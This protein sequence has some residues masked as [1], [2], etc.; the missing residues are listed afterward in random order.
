MLVNRARNLRKNPTEAERKLWAH[1]RLRQIGGYKFRRQHPLGPFIVDFVCIEKRL[2]VEVDG[3]QHDEKRF[4]DAKRN[5][6][7]EEREFKVIRFWNN[8][9]LRD[10]EIV[11]EVIAN[12][13]DCD[14]V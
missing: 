10:I 11:T 3:G 13:L 6:W 12:E 5:E 14:E 9:V 2:I 1:L 8:E 7:L 4:Y